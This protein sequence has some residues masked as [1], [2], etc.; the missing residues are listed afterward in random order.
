MGIVKFNL[1]SANNAYL[2][3][4]NADFF[5]NQ[6]NTSIFNFNNTSTF[7]S[8]EA[9]DKY[10]Q[11][12]MN[13]LDELSKN[14][15]EAFKNVDFSNT[16]ATN[17]NTNKA[18]SSKH[19]TAAST[20]RLTG[21]LGS[22]IVANANKYLGYKEADG[23][24]KLFTNGRTEAWCADFVTH[25]VKESAQANGKSLP[26]FGSSSVEGLRQWGL[27]NNCYL[28]TASVTNK[29]DTI[30]NKVKPGDAVIFKENGTSH[31]GVVAQVNSD[32]SFK[33]IEGNTSDK[34]AYRN[35][36]ANDAKISGFVQVA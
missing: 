9:F 4:N 36:S 25:V 17:T 31:T 13:Y 8:L 32:G 1:A 27:Q 10:N 14:S 16:S 24:Y 18:S 35:Y 11:T 33:T 6:S 22:D 19:S 23:S 34:V 7:N 5:S 21:N 15:Y 12:F 29:A 26:G 20:T 3:N 2:N 30:K 28:E